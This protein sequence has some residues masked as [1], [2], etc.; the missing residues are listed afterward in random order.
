MFTYDRRTRGSEEFQFSTELFD[1]KGIKSDSDLMMALKERPSKSELPHVFREFGTIKFQ[2]LLDF[3]SYRDLQRH[4]SAYQPMP[5][6]TLENGF[7][8]WY[9][10]NL[11]DNLKREAIE[12]L[13]KQETAV[14]SLDLEPD[15]DQYLI[16][17]GYRI[18]VTMVCSL[19]SAAYIAELRSAQ[20]V[21]PTLRVRA[22]QMGNAL[23][24]TLPEMALYHDTSADVW[25][26]ARGLQDIVEIKV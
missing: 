12:L 23:K 4:R 24:T 6:L 26:V 25:N 10:D 22:Q 1:R 15:E 16:P 9:L 2:F 18:P 7:D 14:D 8:R 11:T 19:P 3:G 13:N 17:M 5:K 21:H 20:T